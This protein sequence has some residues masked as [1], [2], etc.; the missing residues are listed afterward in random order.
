MYARQEL[1]VYV[2]DKKIEHFDLRRQLSTTSQYTENLLWTWKTVGST[3]LPPSSL[4][5][6]LT[7]SKILLYWQKE[8]TFY[9][10]LGLF[11]AL[12]KIKITFLKNQHIF[13]R[14]K[15]VEHFI[16]WLVVSIMGGQHWSGQ[17]TGAKLTKNR[18]TKLELISNTYID[19]IFQCDGRNKKFQKF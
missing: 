2:S 18:N 19:S 8:E 11:I 13:S 9:I 4:H 1:S 16:F 15:I 14:K 17:H 6:K 12:L 5:R 7:L 3:N 10:W